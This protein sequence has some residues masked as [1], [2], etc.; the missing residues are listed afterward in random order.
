MEIDNEL[1]AIAGL[2]RLDAATMAP[3]DF[4]AWRRVIDILI[5]SLS[6]SSRNG[7]LLVFCRYYSLGLMVR[8]APCW[9]WDFSQHCSP[10]S[11]S[12]TSA[13]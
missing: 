11:A 8:K 2:A 10:A 5:S 9:R 7:V 4:S 1:A 12:V 13:A 3:A 6:V